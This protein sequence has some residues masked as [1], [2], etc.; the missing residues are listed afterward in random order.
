[1]DEIKLDDSFYPVEREV[2]HHPHVF[3]LP[4]EPPSWHA[5]VKIFD[6]KCA[7]ILFS[8]YHQQYASRYQNEGHSQS[9]VLEMADS[10]SLIATNCLK[11]FM[12]QPFYQVLEKLISET[13]DFYLIRAN[14]KKEFMDCLPL[15]EL[16]KQVHAPIDKDIYLFLITLIDHPTISCELHFFL[17]GYTLKTSE[18]SPF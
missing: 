3:V 2:Q 6:D 17:N 13:P 16:N 9:A 10:Q 15:E 7:S 12:S 4:L 11:R 8:Y 5:V 18:A 14:F 1:M